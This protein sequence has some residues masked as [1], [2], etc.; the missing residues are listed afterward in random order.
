[1]KTNFTHYSLISFFK[2]IMVCLIC[3]GSY[4]LQAQAQ[5]EYLY[6]SEAAIEVFTAPASNGEMLLVADSYND[7]AA[8]FHRIFLQRIDLQGNVTQTAGIFR[9]PSF[10]L[11]N[12]MATSDNGVLLMG[13]VNIPLEDE[14]SVF[15]VKLDDMGQISWAKGFQVQ[16]NIH[17][18]RGAI[19]T[20]DGSYLVYGTYEHVNFAEGI[21]LMKISNTGSLIWS[22]TINSQLAGAFMKVGGVVETASGN[23][24]LSGSTRFNSEGSWLAKLNSM[25]VTQSVTFYN[26]HKLTPSQP[27]PFAIFG[28]SNGELDIFYNSTAF[29]SGPIMLA[30]RADSNGMPLK[31]TR[32]YNAN[33]FGEI[34]HVTPSGD[35]GYLGCGYYFPGGVFRSK[36]FAM[37]IGG[38]YRTTWARSYGTDYIEITN[39]IHP[40]SDGGHVLGGFADFDSVIVS[41]SENG[42]FPWLIKTDGDGLTTCYDNKSIATTKDTAVTTMTYQLDNVAGVALAE[43]FFSNISIQVNPDSVS[44]NTTGSEKMPTS[45]FR[46]YPNPSQGRIFVEVEGREVEAIEVFDLFGKRVDFEVEKAIGRIEIRTNFKGIGI[47]KIQTID[48]F[49][50]GKLIVE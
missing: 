24:W 32:Y 9:P 20:S 46:M 48:G 5:F 19:E 40:T 47:V 28:R 27:E 12:I 1:M 39:S 38:D 10:R 31:A 29:Q 49:W 2:S 23:L 34:T 50:A 7:T 14:D 4:P 13:T 18:A 33:N 6:Q 21:F 11:D 3:V 15:V 30:I 16:P 42:L 17:V 25:G 26:T 8:Y 43:V 41:P 44:C 36:G 35:G 37:K 45:T 22:R